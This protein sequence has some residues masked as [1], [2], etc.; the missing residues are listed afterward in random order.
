MRSEKLFDERGVFMKRKKSRL[1]SLLIC[2][3]MLSSLFMIPGAF[4]VVAAPDSVDDAAVT[5]EP[6]E[7]QEARIVV[8]SETGGVNWGCEPLVLTIRTD[9]VEADLSVSIANPSVVSG[10]LSGLNGN[11]LTLVP[12]GIVS[13]TLVTVTATVGG[14]KVSTSFRVTV[15]KYEDTGKY[16]WGDL[17][18]PGGGAICG[19]VFHPTVPNLL[20]AHTDVGGAWKF[21][22]DI[23][24]WEDI[25]KWCSPS[26]Q[27][28]GQSRGLAVDPTP[29]RESWVYILNNQG[30]NGVVYR[31][32][33]FGE[34]WVRLGATGT[35]AGGNSGNTRGIGGNFYIKPN[36][37]PG[38]EGSKDPAD[39]GEPTMYFATTN[40]FSVSRDNGMTWTNLGTGTSN[41]FNNGNRLGTNGQNQTGFSFV[42]YDHYNLNFIVV[43][44]QGTTNGGK[45]DGVFY[46]KD[47]GV[48]WQVLPDQ[49]QPRGTTTSTGYFGCKAEFSAPHNA[50]GDRYLF[51]TFNDSNAAAMGVNDGYAGDGCVF[52]WLIDKDGNILGY[53]NITPVSV[54]D[55]YVKAVAAT[56]TQAR[57]SGVGYCGVS[58][59][60]QIPG[61]LIVSSHGSDYGNAVYNRLLYHRSMDTTFRSL[62]YGETWFPV[63]CGFNMYGD[64]RNA[65]YAPYSGPAAKPCNVN[66]MDPW[67]QIG[68]EYWWE[69]WTF[70]HWNYGPQINP[71]DSDNMFMNSGIGVY[72]T[73]N[74]TALDD[75]NKA[76]P[77]S[78]PSQAA[79]INGDS[80]VGLFTTTDGVINR[81]RQRSEYTP[82]RIG[83]SINKLTPA[84]S[85]KWEVAP[86]LEMTVLK[87]STLFSPPSGKNIAMTAIWDYG[88]F[89]FTSLSNQELP[90]RSWSY[91]RYIPEE[92]R[93]MYDGKEYAPTNYYISGDCVDYVDG[94][95]DIIVSSARTEWHFH[96]QGGI[97]LSV[98]EGYSFNNI[99][100]GYVAPAGWEQNPPGYMM[101]GIGN[102]MPTQALQTSV[103]RQKT[104]MDVTG[105]HIAISADAKTI[106][107]GV[108]AATPAIASTVVSKADVPTKLGQDWLLCEFYSSTNA[109]VTT[110]NARVVSDRVDPDVFYAF[111]TNIYVSQDGGLTFQQATVTAADGFTFPAVANMDREIRGEVGN[112]YNIWV[113]GNGLYKL[114][115]NKE[116]NSF[117]TRRI[118]SATASG[119]AFAM[120]NNANGRAGLG[121]G[122]GGAVNGA[123]YAYG[124]KPAV[125]GEQQTGWGVYRS[126]D[127]GETWVKVSYSTDNP[128]PAGTEED[129]F[130]NENFQFADVRGLTGDPR[131]FGRVYLTQGNVS[132]G[133]RYGNMITNLIE[134]GDNT[135][136]GIKLTVGKSGG[137][138]YAELKNNSVNEVSGSI[139]VA[140]Y[141]STGKLVWT[142]NKPVKIAAGAAD[143]LAVEVPGGFDE[144][145]IKAFAWDQQY[146][147]ITPATELK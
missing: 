92:W 74:L 28:V 112:A 76:E 13:N 57:Q 83:N 90:E 41:P 58:I 35:N 116:T 18:I 11:I 72:V 110:G 77:H 54:I 94:N 30:G 117:I 124:R 7:D 142:A 53:E 143:I 23:K 42:N 2:L 63:F 101:Y 25:T 5:I 146:V 51:V 46:S 93:H 104:T 39:Y 70:S 136:Q 147:P 132:G 29:G 9:P 31:S 115:Y 14:T 69:P 60:P 19:Y 105:G 61:A 138:I 108:N 45:R 47:N 49:P 81:D 114:T 33:D 34:T 137:N 123:I 75:I 119:N 3:A 126:L 56:G 68:T 87:T 80:R 10:S 111:G 71:F 4:P 102:G 134:S 85:V 67:T 16:D 1:V 50:A 17:E 38:K 40:G 133:V 120:T 48:T 125:K 144:L 109:R 113:S 98:D 100:D 44:T 6:I 82:Y 131:I 140:A 8:A 88:G 12:T 145:H 128:E 64:L 20:Y 141:D 89:A 106:V 78:M 91:T 36:P 59:D 122:V 103:N 15:N 118:V 65:D 99:P 21:N 73:W 37:N 43:G 135:E 95:P 107:W 84:Q 127:G 52:R 62:D 129:P 32:K 79:P 97:I 27:N 121:L 24:R 96:S 26:L 22:F 139:I 86:G 55:T 130:L 66:N